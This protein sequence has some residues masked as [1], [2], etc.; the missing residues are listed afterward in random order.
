MTDTEK[1]I[2]AA[3]YSSHF[4]DQY[5]LRD[6]TGIQVHIPQS[7]EMAWSAVIEAREAI[8]VVREGWGKDDEVSK[9]LEEMVKP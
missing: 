6:T 5:R 3:A 8:P 2:W 9:M 1:L 4:I 7:I